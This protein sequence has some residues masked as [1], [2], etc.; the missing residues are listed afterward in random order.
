VKHYNTIDYLIVGGGT[1]GCI[2]AARLSEDAGVTVTLLEEGPRDSSPYIRIPGTYYK[3]AQGPLLK[4]YPWDAPAEFGRTANDTMIQASVLGGGSSING[5]VYIRGNPADYDQ[6]EASGAAG[7]NYQHLLPYFRRAENN[8]DFSGEQ[9]G[10]DG[11]VGVAFPAHIHPLTKRWLQACQQFGLHYTADFNAG[12]QDGCGIYQIAARRG[13][14]SSSASAYLRP[15]MHRKNLTVLTGARVTRIL[16]EHGRASGVQCVRG[17][18]SFELRAEREVVLTAGAINTPKLLLLSGIGAAEDLRQHRIPVHAD[19]PGVGRN[20]QDHVEASQV[21]QLQGV[22][23]Y[24]KYKKLR[25][26]TWAA[27]Q[28][29]ATR[30]GPLASNLVE[31]GAFCRGSLQQQ[32]PDL[33]FFF[34]VGAGIEEGTDTVPGGTGCTLTFEHVRPH[35]RGFV[36]LRSGDASVPPRIVPNYMTEEYDVDRLCEGFLIGQEMMKQPAFSGYV[37]RQ[38]DP[39]REFQNGRELRDYLRRV[40]RPGLHPGGTC[41]MGTDAMSV[42]DPQLRVRGIERLRV[43]DASIMPNVPAGNTNAACTMIAEKASDLVRGITVS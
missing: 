24:D 13:L 14:R 43:A 19:L 1:T 31:G 5:M 27:L 36:S 39:G 8:A 20:L 16:I 21:Y 3:T 29:L 25:W 15:V 42:V 26:K 30:G 28:Y 7:W 37:A 23:S 12:Q 32:L 6:W 34:I 33:Q 11:P 10:M 38:H 35:S 2:L 9:H 4:R 17:G 18:R 22:D 40:G 41:K